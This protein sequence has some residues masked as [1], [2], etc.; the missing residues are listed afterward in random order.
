MAL[1]ETT[2]VLIGCP[3]D[4]RLRVATCNRN[5]FLNVFFSLFVCFFLFSFALKVAGNLVS[6]VNAHFTLGGNE[7]TY[8][9]GTAHQQH[10]E[11]KLTGPEADDRR[12]DSRNWETRRLIKEESSHRR[13]S[14]VDSI[15][16]AKSIIADSTKNR[17]F[18]E[19]ASRRRHII[20]E[21]SQ[22]SESETEVKRKRVSFAEEL[23]TAYSVIA[24]D[25]I[26]R[27]R[28]ENS[29]EKRLAIREQTSGKRRASLADDIEIAKAII[30]ESPKK[31][32]LP[33]SLVQQV[34]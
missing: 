6:L 3:Y 23:E 28:L 19:R 1:C 7:Q 10:E 18:E 26:Y 15:T 14:L 16:I 13:D 20:K 24:P 34:L 8:S 5:A 25:S 27:Q 30:F 12:R 33:V 4:F 22:G 9:G 21:C 11:R 29:R 32:T 31:Y 2:F 17:K